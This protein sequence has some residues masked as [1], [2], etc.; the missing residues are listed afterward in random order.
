VPVP[1]GR[2]DSG[3]RYLQRRGIDRGILGSSRA[4]FWVGIATWC[5]RFARRTFGNQSE[6]VYRGTLRPGETLHIGHKA[7]TYAGKRVRSRRRKVR[8]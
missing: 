5:L 1:T 3:L 2:I 6:L 7:E 8:A 4:W